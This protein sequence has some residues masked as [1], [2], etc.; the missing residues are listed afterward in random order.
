[1]TK[2]RCHQAAAP[3][4]STTQ[5]KAAAGTFFFALDS[6]HPDS[7]KIRVIRFW[8]LSFQIGI[9]LKNQGDAQNQKRNCI[10]GKLKNKNAWF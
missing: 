3:F 7:W 5:P 9:V 8:T 2:H 6:G 4:W 1:M 10:Q